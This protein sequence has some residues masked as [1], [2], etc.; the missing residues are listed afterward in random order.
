[1][2]DLTTFRTDNFRDHLK[3]V[4]INLPNRSKP[5]DEGVKTTTTPAVATGEP[6]RIRGT[7]ISS[8]MQQDGVL[9][10]LIDGG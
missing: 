7:A 5:I 2:V 3:V 10:G 1:M 4:F 9:L 6:L 8:P